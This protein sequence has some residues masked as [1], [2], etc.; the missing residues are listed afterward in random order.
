[1]KGNEKGEA[2]ILNKSL[3]SGKKKKKYS[4][5]G[6]DR[7]KIVYNNFVLNQPL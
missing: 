6:N 7:N 2:D 4:Q 5:F 1:M 3:E